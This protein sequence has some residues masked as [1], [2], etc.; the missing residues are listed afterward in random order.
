M[1]PRGIGP[2]TSFLQRKPA[3][4]PATPENSGDL[5]T[6]APDRPSEMAADDGRSPAIRAPASA[7]DYSRFVGIRLRQTGVQPDSRGGY[8]AAVD[9]ALTSMFAAFMM[10]VYL[11][12]RWSTLA[13]L[14]PVPVA[15]VYYLAWQGE[16][17]P[18]ASASGD[19]QP[20]L[21][22][23]VGVVAVL[24]TV[25][26]AGLGHLVRWFRRRSASRVDTG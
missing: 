17:S 26:A 13:W 23:F 1:E 14:A 9:L 12:G 22:A 25:A 18:S 24:L 7:T 6:G 19:P 10:G 15:V 2:L 5:A 8:A 21:I 3:E 20:G 11:P 16:R 4:E